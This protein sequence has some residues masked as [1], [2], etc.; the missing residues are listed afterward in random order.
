MNENPCH[1]ESVGDEAG[2][3]AAGAAEAIECITCHVIAALD[4][5]FFDRVRH[6]FDGDFDE[7][8]GNLLGAAPVA[9]LFCQGSKSTVNCFAIERQV[10][11]RSENLRDRKSVV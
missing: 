5:Y 9:Y 1:P 4:G 7:A 2:M 8:V 3:L 10:L 6:V 11:L